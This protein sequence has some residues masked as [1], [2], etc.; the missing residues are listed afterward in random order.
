[1]LLLLLICIV[2]SRPVAGAEPEKA[3]VFDFELIDTSLEGSIH[4]KRPDET[5]RLAHITQL[6]REKLAASGKY[7]L[8][9]LAPAAKAISDA[10]PLNKCNGCI[11]DLAKSVGANVAFTGYVQKVSNLILNINIEVRDVQT[12]KK[13]DVWSADIRGNTDESWDHGI[14]WLVNHRVLPKEA[15]HG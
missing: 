15:P 11:E 6:L 5:A 1:M 14:T 8:V 2:A 4:G 7:T 9:D 10:A 13:L 12:G 3:A